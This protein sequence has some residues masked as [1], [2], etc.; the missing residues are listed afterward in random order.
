MYLIHGFHQL[1]GHLQQWDGHQKLKNLKKFYP[2]SVLVTGFDIIFFWVARMLMMGNYFQKAILHL[3]KFM[4][5]L[6]LEMKKDKKCQ[7]QKAML[8]IHLN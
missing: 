8:L 5:M 2:T 1:Y 3:K 4:S 7:N 6:L